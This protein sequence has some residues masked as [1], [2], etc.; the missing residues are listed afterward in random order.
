[1]CSRNPSVGRCSIRRPD[2]ISSPLHSYRSFSALLTATIPLKSVWVLTEVHR[3]V[4]CVAALQRDNAET[5][6]RNQVTTP[7]NIQ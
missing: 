7:G 6:K 2:N 1:M 5:D 3:L 4:K